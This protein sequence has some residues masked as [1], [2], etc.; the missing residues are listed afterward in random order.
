MIAVTDTGTGIPPNI[1]ERVY[2]PFFTTKAEDKG[3]GLGL[4]MVYGFLKQS[5]G[6]VKIYSEID[7]GT[8][9]KV[10]LPRARSSASAG[11]ESA[12]S[13]VG[14]LGSETIMVVEDEPDVRSYLVETLRDLNYN[15]RE[16]PDGN[17]ALALFDKDPKGVDLLLTDIVMPGLNG[18]ELSDRLQR[19]QPSLK[20]L[21]MTGYS[22]N[23]IV[24]Q[25]RLDPGVSLLQKP[26]TQTMLAAKIRE[27]LDKR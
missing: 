21:F 4:A 3:T 7:E 14:S 1:L 25:G 20:V 11:T 16:A 12:M 19:R 15:V 8:T 5:G 23:A 13:V 10:Y 24:H 22:R 17:A 2:E 6:H 9:I 26:L 18:R 27:V